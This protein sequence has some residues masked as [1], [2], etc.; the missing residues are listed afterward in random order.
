MR[1]VKAAKKSKGN[2]HLAIV[3]QNIYEVKMGWIRISLHT[4]RGQKKAF[5]H[6]HPKV[7]SPSKI[8][9]LHYFQSGQKRHKRVILQTTLWLLFMLLC[10]CMCECLCLCL[11]AC[12]CND[13][14]PPIDIVYFGS[15]GSS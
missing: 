3:T 9:L 13:P 8:L 2:K 1:H 10:A 5:S 11:C 15:N 7:S 6:H 14:L 4:R 12:V